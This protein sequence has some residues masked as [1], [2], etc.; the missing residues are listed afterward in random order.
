MRG[1]RSASRVVPRTRGRGPSRVKAFNT[2]GNTKM[3][4]LAYAKCSAGSRT[5]IPADSGSWARSIVIKLANSP[6]DSKRTSSQV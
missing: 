6:E 3:E 5:K 1:G 4:V 2:A